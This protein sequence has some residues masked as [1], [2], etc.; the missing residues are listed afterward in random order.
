MTSS[1][2]RPVRALLAVA[3]ACALVLS[4]AVLPLFGAAAPADDVAREVGA[5]AGSERAN[6]TTGQGSAGPAGSGGRG[7]DAAGGGGGLGDFG[8]DQ[9][10]LL[11][12]DGPSSL[13]ESLAG[14]GSGG[15]GGSG[16]GSGGG[17]GSGGSGAAGSG[18]AV[19]PGDSGGG[20]GGGFVEAFARL[21][22]GESG[23]QAGGSDGST[24][25]EAGDGTDTP[26]SLV[27]AIE[28]SGGQCLDS[29]PYVV[30]FPNDPVPGG[31]TR[32]LVVRDGEPVPDVTVTFNGEAV[33]RT[34]GDGFVT[35][36]V[37]FVRQLSVGVRT[38]ANAVAV[39]GSQSPS[40][41]HYS[42]S[43]PD[44]GTVSVPVDGELELRLAGDPGPGETTT[45]RVVFDDTP[46]P[47]ATVIV[48]GERVGETDISGQLPAVL[49]VAEST[50]VRA[51]RGEFATER[52]VTLADIEVSL[53][54][55]VLP[56]GL[57]GRSAT[58]D[59][60][61]GGSPVA[62]AT[63]AVDG[64]EAGRTG[65]DGTLATTLPLAPTVDVTVTTAAGLTVTRSQ[66]VFVTPLAVLLGLLALAGGLGY[67]Y[68]ESG[69]SGRSLLEELRA[70][71][72][73]LAADLL[74]GL[75]GFASGAEGTFAALRE[76]VR[77]TVAAISAPDVDLGA[78]ARERLIALRAAL[79]GLLAVPG[80]RVRS[81]RERVTG[82]SDEA[83]TADAPA[84]GSRSLDP[85]ERVERAWARF[86][87]RI[88]VRRTRTT[89]PGEVA[90]RGLD[91][92]FPA[93]PVRQ[94]T[95]AFR[96]VEYS[97]ADPA[98]HADHAEQAATEL[99]IDP[100]TAADAGPD[101]PAGETDADGEG[102]AHR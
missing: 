93:E 43:R 49:P 70:T 1:G 29:D 68:R 45:V 21:F 17:G 100:A 79:L 50:T 22:G 67:L 32:V 55:E 42:L 59:V 98:D 37:P 14:G 63:V 28:R 16:A 71:L 31:E 25:S 97:D 85:R 27:E 73:D 26:S 10:G 80:E 18:G 62:N 38:P 96:A 89:T 61:D 69:V 8:L 52:S 81:L 11:S 102:D 56:V 86:V 99:D 30:C 74:S 82:S 39:P 23:E 9:S 19:E 36:R 24:G 78:Y 34:D 13:F 95:D 76:Q 7:G 12:G 41:R 87:D 5:L 46:V 3:A 35:A 84:A 53:R 58:L 44:N 4:A 83:T 64:S 57:P 51:E 94:L 75:V 65:A 54:S 90:G 88:G 6:A 20:D 2:R 15:S 40:D 72:S 92:G 33:G 77:A 101:E 47:N 60:I 66:A 48:G 91:E